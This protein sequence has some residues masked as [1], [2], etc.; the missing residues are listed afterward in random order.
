MDSERGLTDAGKKQAEEMA[1]WMVRQ[2]GRCDIVICSP[3]ARALKTAEPMAE[4]LGC[5]VATTTLLEPNQKPEAAWKEIE[6]LAQ[7]SADVLVIGHHPEIGKLADWL[8]DSDDAIHARL[9]FVHGAIAMLDTTA[10]K[11]IWFVTPQLVEKDEAEQEVVEAAKALLE[12][13]E[14]I[15]FTAHV[16][17]VSKLEDGGELWQVEEMA[18]AQESFTGR[19]QEGKKIFIDEKGEYTY[20][21]QEMKRWVLGSGGKSGE[22]CEA[23]EEN[24]DMGWIDMDATFLTPDGDDIDDAPAHPNCDCTVEQATKR[25]RVYA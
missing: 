10:Q 15:A 3:F 21:E 4:A 9:H 6:R 5:H 19:F 8:V 2:V 25:V 12:A 20:D 22:N 11:L 18:D 23:C 14:P 24:A 17:R 16:R 13:D 7:A 1:A